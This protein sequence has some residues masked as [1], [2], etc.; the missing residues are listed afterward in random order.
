MCAVISLEGGDHVTVDAL[1][2]NLRREIREGFAQALVEGEDAG[3][4]ASATGLGRMIEEIFRKEF[5]EQRPISSAL[6]LFG[7]TANAVLGGLTDASSHWNL[8][9]LIAQIRRW[10][11]RIDGR[12]VT[13]AFGQIRHW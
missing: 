12:L 7:V 10:P 8:H 6:H 13:R 5:V 9:H 4:V 1:P 11:C 3:L 2:M